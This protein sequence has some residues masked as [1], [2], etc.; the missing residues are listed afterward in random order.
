[1]VDRSTGLIVESGNRESLVNAMRRLIKDDAMRKA[2]GVSAREFT[3][4]NGVRA[5][6]AYST[7]LRC[8]T[9]NSGVSF[10]P[11]TPAQVCAQEE[12]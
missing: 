4:N 12:S 7:I 2:M 6:Q 3:L 5:S 1:M 8:S 10:V 9:D 11:K